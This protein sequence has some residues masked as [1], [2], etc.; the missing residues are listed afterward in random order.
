MFDTQTRKASFQ[1]YMP[2]RRRNGD[3]FDSLMEVI[4]LVGEVKT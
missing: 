2:E 1:G 3:S 4:A